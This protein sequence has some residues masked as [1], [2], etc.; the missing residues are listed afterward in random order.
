MYG[1]EYP[2]RNAYACLPSPRKLTNIADAIRRSI[3]M[4]GVIVNGHTLTVFSS[5]LT[6]HLLESTRLKPA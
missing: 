2:F 3:N 1:G 6:G 4:R 5:L